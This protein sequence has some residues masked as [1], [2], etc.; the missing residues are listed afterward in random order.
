VRVITPK[1][2]RGNLPCPRE[3]RED[4]VVGG[5]SSTAGEAGGDCADHV[6]EH[7]GGLA[8]PGKQHVLSWICNW[9]RARCSTCVR[10]SQAARRA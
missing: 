3:R 8:A 9:L 5:F 1:A 10:Y 6:G 7:G 2:V 4:R